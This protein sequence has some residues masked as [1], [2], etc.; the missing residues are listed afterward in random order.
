[1]HCNVYTSRTC[2]IAVDEPKQTPAWGA[3]SKFPNH[4]S[5]NRP[6]TLWPYA[7]DVFKLSK[8]SMQEFESGMNAILNLTPVW[9]FLS[10]GLFKFWSEHESYCRSH[11]LSSS[12]SVWLNSPGLRHITS[13]CC[14][15]PQCY[16]LWCLLKFFHMFVEDC[17]P[18]V[19]SSVACWGQHCCS[20][21]CIV[22]CAMQLAV[23]IANVLRILQDGLVLWTV[24]ALIFLAKFLSL[25]EWYTPLLSLWMRFGMAYTCVAVSESFRSQS[26]IEP[27]VT[28]GWYLIRSVLYSSLLLNLILIMTW[29]DDRFIP[30]SCI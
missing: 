4:I 3:E 10:W 27:W 1:M 18:L 23:S 17:H 15:L 20:V 12:R 22:L 26:D 19:E 29:E 7:Q 5:K 9:I 24:P 8:L 13:S 2:P 21:L 11:V 14:S 30:K 6:Q 16:P 28:W 25:L